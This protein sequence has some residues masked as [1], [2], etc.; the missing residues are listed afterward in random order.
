MAALTRCYRIT[1]V[2]AIIGFGI[3][4]RVLLYVEDKPSAWLHF[5]ACRAVVS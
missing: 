1:A 4:V 2:L 3:C 5:Y